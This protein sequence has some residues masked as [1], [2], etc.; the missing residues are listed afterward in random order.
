MKRI[1]NKSKPNYELIKRITS[2]KVSP[3]KGSHLYWMWL[4]KHPESIPI[5]VK[6]GLRDCLVGIG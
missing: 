1:K 4:G 2:S 3:Y 5:I 6:Y